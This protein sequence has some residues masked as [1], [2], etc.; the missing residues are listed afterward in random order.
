MTGYSRPLSAAARIA[1]GII[2]LVLGLV[3]LV[4]PLLPGI[5]LLILAAALLTT[6]ARRTSATG[7][8]RLERLQLR[9]WLLLKRGTAPL[10]RVFDR[11]RRVGPDAT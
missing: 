11:P 6:S 1:S 3:G 10:A 5:P 7:L 2:C 8:T 4:I 9:G